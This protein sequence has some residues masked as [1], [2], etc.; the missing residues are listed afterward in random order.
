MAV[1]SQPWNQVNFAL[2]FEMVINK[3]LR[4]ANQLST[5]KYITQ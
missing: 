1:E 3:M 4:I 5:E 2:I